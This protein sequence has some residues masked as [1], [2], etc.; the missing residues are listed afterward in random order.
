M[1]QRK[2]IFEYIRSRENV[3]RA[4]QTIVYHSATLSFKK[5]NIYQYTCIRLYTRCVYMWMFKNICKISLWTV[6][7]E[8]DT[9]WLIL[10]MCMHF[11]LY[12]IFIVNLRLRVSFVTVGLSF[13]PSLAFSQLD[14]R[15]V[16]TFVYLFDCIWFAHKGV[17]VDVC[18]YALLDN[19]FLLFSFSHVVIVFNCT[20]SL[21]IIVYLRWY[22]Y[23]KN[24]NTHLKDASQKYNRVLTNCKLYRQII[25]FRIGI[26]INV[27]GF[28]FF[29][30]IM[31][32]R[33]YALMA[34]I[35]MM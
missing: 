24:A 10:W 34:G 11:T 3:L 18:A 20:I 21:S 5:K 4:W 16:S 13:L 7:G 28:F 33:P 15:T 2:P 8:R 26:G 19:M 35:M 30:V 9:R 32:T 31:R 22:H 25:V 17:C 27:S 6:N 23:M 29:F 12:G 1:A 14:A